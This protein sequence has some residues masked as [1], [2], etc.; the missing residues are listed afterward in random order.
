MTAIITNQFRLQNLQYA[1]RDID[2]GVDKY[3][4]AIGRS[5]S[6]T[7]DSNPPAPNIDPKDEMEARLNMQS[8]KEIADIVYCAPRYNWTSGNTYVAWDNNDPDLSS[9]QFYVLEQDTFNVY[10]CLRAGSGAS[11][12]KP[13]GTATG[14]P[15]EEADGYVWKFLYTISAS[16]AD[17]FLTSDFI[18]VFRD[19]S[20][21]A[22]A[23][24]GQ[25]WDYNIVSGG[26]GYGSTPTL[27][28][29]GDGT[30]ATATATL[31]G[32]V[33]TGITVTGVGSGYS[34]AR[35]VIS[36]GSPSTAAD[37]APVISPVSLGR[38][39]AG[40]SISNG[41]TSYTTG[42]LGLTV[43]GDGFEAAA[44][45][46]VVAGVID[47]IAI[48]DAGYSYTNCTV[49]PNETTAG[50]TAVLVPQFSVVKG[51]FGYDPVVDLQAHYLMFNVVLTGAE[52]SGDFVPGNDY[53]QLSILKNPLD[54]SGTQLTFTDSTGT[55]MPYLDVVGGG[56]WS[57][58]DLI[59]GG[60]S[61]AQAYVVYYDSSND[62]LYYTQ[63]EETGFEA[64]DNSEAV[65]G[66]SSSGTIAASGASNPSEID[67]FSGRMMYLENRAPVSRAADQTEDIKIVVQF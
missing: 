41:G 60:T 18:P 6:W 1:K 54:R 56:T 11:T 61:G 49:T 31:T 55:A 38:E 27:D 47:S 9:K 62:F 53:R 37:I 32:G 23:T 3:Y 59:T 26:T 8:A 46:T 5:T 16:D 52:G 44:T 51:G 2:S 36:G 39:L 7:V 21:A 29:E 66:A 22:A 57:N 13:N 64:F 28:V 24:E 65:T 17:K 30:G 50:T 48:D 20:V 63:N 15:S 34:Y 10:I 14:N 45:A 67:N 42:S 25:I 12:V 58:D 33:I 40:V 35:V 4:L 19:A 43:E